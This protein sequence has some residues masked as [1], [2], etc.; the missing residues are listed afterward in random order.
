MIAPT[1]TAQEF[2]ERG[3]AIYDRVI[4]PVAE[5][6]QNGKFVVINI[7]TGSFEIDKD[8]MAASLRLREREPQSV[9]RQ[10]F[11]MVGKPYAHQRLGFRH[12]SVK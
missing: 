7:D 9:G 11:R 6:S 2:G 12:R 10:W 3:D 8:E 4:R 5:P 1:L